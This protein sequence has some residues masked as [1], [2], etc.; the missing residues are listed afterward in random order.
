MTEPE[1]ILVVADTHLR[2]DRADEIVDIVGRHRLERAD[3]ILHAGDVVSREVLDRLAGFAP[4]HAVDGNN[5]VDL[6]LPHVLE[7]EIGARGPVVAR[8]TQPGWWSRLASSIPMFTCPRLKS[9]FTQS[10]CAGVPGLDAF[11]FF[12]P[13][14][15]HQALS[16]QIRH[17]VRSHTT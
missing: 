8:S 17:T 10:S 6:G 4:L 5:D 7:V 13:N 11:P 16:R 1:R 12:W 14:T 2:A 9:R 3:A 15:D